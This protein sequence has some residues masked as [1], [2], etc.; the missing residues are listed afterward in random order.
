MV[1]QL[2]VPC[3]FTHLAPHA[4]QLLTVV[5]STSQPLAGLESQSEWLA[6]QLGLHS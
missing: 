1:L 2:A 3:G 4:P 6:S 5:M